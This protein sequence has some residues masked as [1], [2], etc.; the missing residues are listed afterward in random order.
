M[1]RRRM[2]KPMKPAPQA[3]VT[4]PAGQPVLKAAEDKIE[5]QLLPEIRES[6]LKIVVAG[7]KAGLSGGPKSII[8]GLKDSKDPLSDCAKGA[9]GLVTILKNQARG[10]MPIKAMIPAASTLMIKALS[11]ADQ[12]GVIKVGP[13]ELAKATQIFADMFL[14]KLG[15]T[16]QMLQ[17]AMGKAK[18]LTQDPVAMEMMKRK[19]GFSKHPEAGATMATSASALMARR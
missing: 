10:V 7:M 1:S 4:I 3:P 13:D 6:Y 17:H 18:E 12:M 19:A 9:I 2:K 11:F 16:P 15:V 14:K 8:A 5:S